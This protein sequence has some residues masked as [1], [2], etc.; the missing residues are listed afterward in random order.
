MDKVRKEHDNEKMEG[1][2]EKLTKLRGLCRE[3]T[4]G[5]FIKNNILELLRTKKTSSAHERRLIE[6][7]AV[8]LQ[9][10]DSLKGQLRQEKQKN[11][12]TAEVRLIDY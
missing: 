1:L 12:V 2:Q 4:K 10:L 8:L 9:E 7:K 5:I 6:E 11:A 3:N